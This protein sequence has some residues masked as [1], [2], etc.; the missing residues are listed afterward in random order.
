MT[1][2]KKMPPEEAL[3]YGFGTNP[4]KKSGAAKIAFE[5]INAGQHEFYIRVFGHDY[6]DV[7]KYHVTVD[8]LAEHIAGRS[9]PLY[10][11]N[12]LTFAKNIIIDLQ[13]GIGSLW[14][15]LNRT[16]TVEVTLHK[17]SA[18]QLLS[19]D[20]IL[21]TIPIDLSQEDSPYDQPIK[22]PEKAIT[23]FRLQL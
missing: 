15:E 3:I 8:I 2:Y 19:A 4:A 21:K 13:S 17:K 18:T 1:I 5:G 7:N 10:H 22:I 20:E 11:Q 12:T 6:R 16:S 23:Y 9:I 14:Q